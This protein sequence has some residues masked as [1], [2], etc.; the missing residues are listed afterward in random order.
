MQ[1]MV[2]GIFSV[3][4]AMEIRLNRWIPEKTVVIPKNINFP[5]VITLTLQSKEI[6][7]SN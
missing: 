4:L 6:R 2:Q 1:L 7:N 3:K 5:K